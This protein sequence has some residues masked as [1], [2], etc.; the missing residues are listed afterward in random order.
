MFL[1]PLGAMRLWGAHAAP[2]AGKEKELI[3]RQSPAP[4]AT[5]RVQQCPEGSFTELRKAHRHARVTPAREAHAHV[6]QIRPPCPCGVC[7]RAVHTQ[8]P[9]IERNILQ[10]KHGV[11]WQF[12]GRH[13]FVQK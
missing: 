13:R 2:L 4:L 11:F 7:T 6:N 5:P 8:V 1:D 12:D 10:L 3:R 9:R